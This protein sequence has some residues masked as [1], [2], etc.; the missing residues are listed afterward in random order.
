MSDRDTVADVRARLL[1]AEESMFT[2]E[3]EALLART[4]PNTARLNMGQLQGYR[5][6]YAPSNFYGR[7][8]EDELSYEA[9]LRE[10]ERRGCAR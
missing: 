10:L 1:D 2:A 8:R 7:T 6:A 3:E 4:A 5:D 9:I